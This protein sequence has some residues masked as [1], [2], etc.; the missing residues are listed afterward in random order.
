M[1]VCWDIQEVAAAIAGAE[2]RGPLALRTV[3]VPSMRIAHVLRRELVTSGHAAALIG[4]RFVPAA[5]IAAEVLE[6]AGVLVTPG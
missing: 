4:T 3:I 5:P 6:S 2:A 1:R